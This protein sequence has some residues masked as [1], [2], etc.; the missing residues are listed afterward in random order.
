MSVGL[1][2]SLG[3]LTGEVVSLDSRHELPFFFCHVGCYAV[4]VVALFCV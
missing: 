3:A 1:A 4:G 2:L